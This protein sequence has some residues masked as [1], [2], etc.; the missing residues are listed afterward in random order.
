MSGMAKIIQGNVR[1]F[2]EKEVRKTISVLKPNNELYEIRII[3]Q[4]TKKILSGY[5]DD[6]DKMIE[7]LKKIN[8]S[9]NNVYIT[10]NP[11]KH[12][13][14]ART[15]KD[16]FEQYT[17]AATSDND[18]DGYN[19]LFIDIDPDR[20]KGTSSS[21][22]QLED[23]KNV[24]NK[25]YGFLR[26]M[27]FSKPIM[28]MSGNGVHLLY[29]I[30]LEKNLK[31][32]DLISDCLKTLDML[33]GSDEIKIDQANSN[34][35][36]VCKLYG[37]IAQKGSN[38]PEYP[39]RMSYMLG[40][41]T[42]IKMTNVEYLK[43]LCEL[44]PKQPEKPLAYNN[45]NSREFDLTEWLTKHGISF[46]E[47]AWSGGTKYILECCPF[48]NNHKGKDACI[49]KSSSGAIGFHCFHNSCSD[50][51]WKDVRLLYEPDAYEKKSQ[52]QDRRMYGQRNYNKPKEQSK[53]IVAVDHKPVFYT[54]R[55][56]YD[57][58]YVEE[59]FI[60][61][62]TTQIDQKLRGLKKGYISVVSGM[63]A[64]AKSTL[65]SE[66]ALNA[67]ETG[68]RV[69][70]Y[71]GELTEK[72]F[73]KWMNL[74]AA[75]KAYVCQTQYVNYYT[76][77]RKYQKLI[78]DWLGDRFYLY[79]NY[80]GNNFN[81]IKEQL[82]KNIVEKK[83]DLI[84]LDNLM[85]FNIAALADSKWDSQS[86]FVLQLAEIA[87]KYDIHICFVAHPRKNPGFL[88]L[89]DISGT[90]DLVNAV[91]NA[92]IVHRNNHDFQ[93][94]TQE[95]FGWKDSNE[96]YDSTNVIE[97]AKDRDGGVQDEFV[98]LWY[99]VES[100]RLKNDPAENKIYGW[101]N[102]QPKKSETSHPEPP[103]KIEPQD[104]GWIDTINMETPFD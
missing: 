23:A 98:P 4:K 14:I 95:E 96:I 26:D 29:R 85:S 74:Q 71:S 15:Q 25:I 20:P 18:I 27:G 40:T 48:D 78:A 102:D 104:D 61:T 101:R 49:F 33:F 2:N 32:K 1:M 66:W 86:Q 8:L 103:P 50:K 99:E 91:D 47:N 56:I 13:C 10:L 100:K 46:R 97:I 87:K 17:E 68:N 92:F 58:P 53:P 28:G 65:L 57:L 63:R 82:E 34:P 80:Y 52:E 51:T 73:M 70:A 83:I 67:V 60:K 9:G 45:Y 39:H 62:G 54:A 6:T 12:A 5:F 43:K 44:Y 72:N 64:S 31:T 42:E 22:K 55:D 69:L 37:T 89:E 41:P 94:K 19:W 88:R 21:D 36:R 76:V 16:K 79:N 90:M 3:P 93:K 77:E 35:S 7:E 38:L 81:S 11:L 75:G 84:I 24:G 59:A 30:Y